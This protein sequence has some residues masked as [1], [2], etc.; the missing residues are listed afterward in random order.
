MSIVVMIKFRQKINKD[1]KK[2]IETNIIPL[3]R[4][5]DKGHDIQ[6]VE[7]VIQRSLDLA[8]IYKA[9]LDITYTAAA[10]HDTGLNKGREDHEI[11]S[12]KIVRNDKNLKNFF[13]PEEIEIIAQ[14]VE[15]HRAS[16]QGD[17]RSIYG[18]I[19][20][21]SD[22]IIDPIRTIE[23]TIKFG[24]S[25][26]PDKDYNWHLERSFKYLNNKYGKFG[27]VKGYLSKSDVYKSL[28]E[29]RKIL[30]NKRKFEEIFYEIWKNIIKS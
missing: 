28:Q 25:E 1:L 16:L 3:Y 9:D 20:S 12:G 19:I 5:F 14:A 8:E 27:Y 6:H 22:R 2:Y 21:D 30:D 17:P 18:K 7:E 15:D 26:N 24:L 23:R 4:N 29:F 10:Y 11:N 13:S